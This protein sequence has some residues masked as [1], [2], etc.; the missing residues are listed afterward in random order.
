MRS[1]R[2]VQIDDLAATKSYIERHPTSVEAVELGGIRT[3]LAVPMLKNEKFIGIITI[4]RQQV[5]PFVDK[6]IG[7]VTNF[8]AQ[9]VIAIEN[10][11]LLNELRQRT[12]DL[13]EALDQQ[14]ATA[15][16]LKVISRSQFDLQLVL[17][18]LI[19]TATSLCGAKRGVIFR[20]D[21]DLYHAAAF[22]NATPELIEFVK[23]HP[24][25]PGRHTVTARVALER[26]VIHVADLQ[27]DAEYTYA[28]RDTEPIR[29]EL[30]V[31]MFRG[32]DLVG[33]FI[34]YK[35]KIEPFTDKQ[36]ELKQFPAYLNRWDSQQ[37][38]NEGVF[39]H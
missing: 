37:A 15:D 23:S 24:I 19:E 12:K 6:Q 34:L 7:L 10:A 36:I 33:V 3:M 11:R 5:R 8:A 16:V 1:K 14:T 30:G 32:E 22:Y 28:L 35:L 31:P 29:T 27:E 26:R 21:G 20:A 38:R 9:A 17:D 25:A 39:A 18:N 4:V 2:T 13:G